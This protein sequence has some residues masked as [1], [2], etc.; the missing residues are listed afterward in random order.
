MQFKLAKTYRYWWP[1]AVQIPDPATPGKIIE[2]RL[3]VE[4]E[5]LPQAELM[6]AQEESAKLATLREVTDHGIRQA[7]R[8]VRNW[9]DVVDADGEIVPFSADMLEQALQHAWFR[10]AI[11]KALVESQNGEEARAGN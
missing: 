1:V 10:A 9:A 6:A 5:P 11:Q 3:K 2:Q 7:K 4:F 8:V